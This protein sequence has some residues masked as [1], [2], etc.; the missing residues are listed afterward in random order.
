MQLFFFFFAR[1]GRT[2]LPKKLEKVGPFECDELEKQCRISEKC[3]TKVQK[4]VN[5][6]DLVKSFQTNEV[7]VVYQFC[8][9]QKSAKKRAKRC[10][11]Q[12]KK[13]SIV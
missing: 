11:N 13:N 4:R 2:I 12:K 6:V 9:A 3:Y 5:L 8:G 10:D 7:D 1:I